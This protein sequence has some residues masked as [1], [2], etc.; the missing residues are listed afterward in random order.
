[1]GLDIT[2]FEKIKISDIGISDTEENTIYIDNT[3]NQNPG[4]KVGWYQ[5]EGNSGSFR[6]GTYS[7]YNEFRDA[8]C[9]AIHGISA[10]EF[11]INSNNYIG[12]AFY[13]IIEFSDCEGVFGPDACRKL[14]ND[15][16]TTN[17][18]K[19]I[20]YLKKGESLSGMHQNDLIDLISDIVN[21]GYDQQHDHKEFV[22]VYDD[23]MTAFAD[24]AGTGAV[25]FC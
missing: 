25:M 19:F 14:H 4:L 17:R 6:I 5:T 9:Y 20:H 15:F 18:W 12:S 23:F 24:S 7:Y 22:S 11:W 21:L 8:L 13:E 16:N 3:F 10:Q 2:V 1:M